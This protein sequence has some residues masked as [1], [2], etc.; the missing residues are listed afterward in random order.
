MGKCRIQ[1]GGSGVIAVRLRPRREVHI[2]QCSLGAFDEGSEPGAAASAS[3]AKGCPEKRRRNCDLPPMVTQP[4]DVDPIFDLGERV[5]A[6]FDDL[7]D[8]KEDSRKNLR[9]EAVD[10]GKIVSILPPAVNY[11]RPSIFSMNHTHRDECSFQ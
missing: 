3:G 6:P 10:V 2:E 7:L 5:I 11:T 4:S 8:C 1:Y 9:R